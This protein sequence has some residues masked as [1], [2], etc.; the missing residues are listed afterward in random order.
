MVHVVRPDAAAEHPLEEIILLVGAFGRLEDGERVGTVIVTKPHELLSGELE[1][2][3]P[4][5]FAERRVPVG[6]RG[7]AIARITEGGWSGGCSS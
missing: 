2:L 5:R 3:L 1:C 4:R 7:G 6:R